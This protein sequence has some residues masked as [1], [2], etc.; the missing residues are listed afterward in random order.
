M[1]VKGYNPN[2]SSIYKQVSYNPLIPF[3]IDPSTSN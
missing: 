2:S 1:M 3:T